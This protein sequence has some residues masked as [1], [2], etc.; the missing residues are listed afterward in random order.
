MLGLFNERLKRLCRIVYRLITGQLGSIKSSR[1]SVRALYGHGA[2]VGEN[3]LVAGDVT[4]GSY[5]YINRD[6]TVECCRI[7]AY[8]SISSGV[9]IN[10]WV[11]DETNP[12]TSPLLGGTERD[13]R[14]PVIIDND[15]LVS[16][17]TVICSGVHL[18]TG[19]IVGAG[20][21]VTHDVAPYEKVGGVPARHIGWRFTEEERE[22]LLASSYWN[23]EPK[24][25][26]KVFRNV[27]AK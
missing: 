16:A 25:A 20:A 18:G 2:R 10:P 5:S 22:Q 15:V 9:R 21:V 3:S 27:G 24:A 8:C 1:A 23:L 13:L 26:M 12:S 6:S 7:G 4:I 11:H 19:S 14:Q 17:N